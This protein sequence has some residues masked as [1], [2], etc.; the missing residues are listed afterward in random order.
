MWGDKDVRGRTLLLKRK[1][2]VQMGIE[3]LKIFR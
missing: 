2:G 3:D 1:V